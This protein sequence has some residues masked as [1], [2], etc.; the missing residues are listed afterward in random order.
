MQ[1]PGAAQSKAWVCCR[2]LA[3]IVGSNLAVDMVVGLLCCVL[4]GSGL[5]DG[6]IPRP[7]DSYQICLCVCVCARAQGQ[8]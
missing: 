5:S 3:G 4:S 6:P 7:E 2:P 1:I 8:Q